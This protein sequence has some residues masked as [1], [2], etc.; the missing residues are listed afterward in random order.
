MLCYYLNPCLSVKVPSD[1]FDDTSIFVK[2]DVGCHNKKE[3]GTN[4]PISVKPDKHL[5]NLGY[6]LLEGYL[7]FPTVSKNVCSI[8]LFNEHEHF[9]DRLTI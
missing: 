7:F 3:T 2:V 1:V 6:Y 8:T 4:M 5:N 9:K